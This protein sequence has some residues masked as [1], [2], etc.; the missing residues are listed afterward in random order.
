[1]EV[2]KEV[3]DSMTIS[4]YRKLKNG[5][6]NAVVYDCGED[7]IEVVIKYPNGIGVHAISTKDIKGGRDYLEVAIK[8][9]KVVTYTTPIT[10]D[11]IEHVSLLELRIIM[12]HAKH[13]MP[14]GLDY[15][16]GFTPFKKY[17]NRTIIQEVLQWYRKG[18]NLLPK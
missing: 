15:V 1:V 3:G 6:P 8:H 18:K 10:D 12:D 5:Y 9:G 4:E 7:G 16:D 14:N 17:N 11:V 13:L 2:D